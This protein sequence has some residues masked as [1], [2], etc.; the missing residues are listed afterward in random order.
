METE[1]GRF[2]GAVAGSKPLLKSAGSMGDLLDASELPSSPPSV[3]ELSKMGRDGKNSS[4]TIKR[5]DARGGRAMGS[6]RL[7]NEC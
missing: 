5:R 7:T 4:A 2:S 3:A 6:C 1:A